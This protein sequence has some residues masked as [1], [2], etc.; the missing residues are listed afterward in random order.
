MENQN[1][2]REFEEAAVPASRK[3]LSHRLKKTLIVAAAIVAAV[4][5]LVGLAV[6]PMVSSHHYNAAKNF[7][8][9]FF[10]LTSEAFCY[11]LSKLS[12]KKLYRRALG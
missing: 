4:A 9:Q 8:C 2:V 7:V 10:Y 1:E 3:K 5:V 11:I 12:N 6:P